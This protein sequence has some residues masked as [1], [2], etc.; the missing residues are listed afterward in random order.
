MRKTQYLSGALLL[1]VGW[2]ALPPGAHAQDPTQPTADGYAL[3]D[4]LAR[5]VMTKAG[6]PAP[7]D[8][9][10]GQEGCQR[11]A[12]AAQTIIRFALTTTLAPGLTL[13]SSRAEARRQ[14]AEQMVVDAQSA[15]GQMASSGATTA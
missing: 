2:F 9:D 7:E 5:P 10:G 15:L 8:A 12:Q 14:A 6:L 4:Q 3:Y 11:Y 13:D 1:A